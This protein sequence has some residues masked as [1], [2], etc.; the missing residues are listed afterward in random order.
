MTNTLPT[1][2]NLQSSI[3][4]P[5]ILF[6]SHA[7]TDLLALDQAKRNLDG[8]FPTVVGVNLLS[9]PTEEHVREFIRS[10]LQNIQV[11]VLRSLGGR[12]GFAHGFDLLIQA[13]SQLNI[14]LICVPGTEGLDPELTAHSTVPVPVIHDVYR[15][16]QFGGVANMQQMLHFLADHLMAGGWGYD[17]PA[18]MPRHGVYHPHNVAEQIGYS[19]RAA[20]F[21]D[22]NP[23]L[24]RNPKHP[25]I[26]I[27]FYRSHYLS[28]NT[29]FVDALIDAI[30][31][32]GGRAI[33][34]YT[35]SLKELADEN[36]QPA[37]R[38]PQPAAFQ[39][40]RDDE[41][42]P[43][44][45][46]IISTI[47]FA[48]G[49]IN[50]EG[51][52]SPSW[53]VEALDTLGVPIIQ[54]VTSGMSEQEWRLSQRGLRPLD[55]A[56]NVALPEFDGRIV[57]MPISFKDENRYAPVLDRVEAVVAQAMRLAALRHKPNTEKRIA[58][59]L[60]NS[61]GKADRIGNAVGLDTPASM[62][63]LFAQ[64]KE[65]GYQIENVPKDSDTLLHELINRCS[66]DETILTEEQLAQAAGKVTESVYKAWAKTLTPEQQA[67][68]ADRWGEPPGEAYVHTLLNYMPVNG[69]RDG[70]SSAK[71]DE[72]FIALAG[73]ELGNVFVALQ[74]PARLWHGSR[75]HLPH[76][77]S[78][79]YPQLFCSLSL[80][81]YTG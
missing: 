60:T 5:S 13:A 81:G 52:T 26:G 25:T 63:Q 51:I 54:A 29:D 61:P 6:L 12:Q 68:M 1:T 4:N 80:A 78:T 39:F 3:L 74:P 16:L 19:R 36:P 66:Y 77:R 23:N 50:N 22:P 57:S 58:F 10:E 48:M 44:V 49:G 70:R 27:L 75:C 53:N 64:M 45:D 8:E 71:K 31:G 69:Y 24:N 43:M 42:F 15:Y 67:K 47:S 46:A 79:T 14:D 34:V 9:L 62:L 20:P 7:D 65:Q 35:T 32:A 73:L 11:L 41:E 21:Q 72:R 2:R 17:Q 33:P 18:E 56:M 38:N 55:V 40:F 76:A 37:T 28:G 30:E 59:M